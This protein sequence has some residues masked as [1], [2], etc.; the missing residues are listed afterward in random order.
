[1]S[2]ACCTRAPV[3]ETGYTNKG[4]I[5]PFAGLENTTAYT[6][7]PDNAK[8]V[9]VLVYDAFG[10]GS[11]VQQG[12][13]IISSNLGAKVIMPDFFR[14]EQQDVNNYPPKTD[15]AKAALQEWFKTVAAFGKH[16][17]D[18]QKIVKDIKSKNPD[19]KVGVLGLCWGG[20]VAI[21]AGSEGTA[22]DAV[23]AV[24]P[25]F[26]EEADAHDLAVPLGFFPSKDENRELC[27]KVSEIIA[28]KPF[29]DKN[30]Y[31][32]YETV[33]HGFAGARGNLSDPENKEKYAHFYNTVSEYFKRALEA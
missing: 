21:R 4:A 33:H 7:G 18:V 24:H 20:K 8:T 3:I 16:V 19:T 10:Y 23:A 26:V 22:A 12:A 29:A 17:P 2:E 30:K 31:I 14:G 25:A 11:Q 5:G 9:I 15:E 1:M 28:Q 13:D 6:V 27:E 32:Y